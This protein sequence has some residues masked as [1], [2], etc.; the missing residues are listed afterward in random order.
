MH[1]MT[2]IFKA[3]WHGV[4]ALGWLV[5]GLCVTVLI[6]RLFGAP[7]RFY[8]GFVLWL[9]FGWIA[10][11][12][13]LAFSGLHQGPLVSRACAVLALLAFGALA[14]FTLMPPLPKDGH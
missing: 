7:G 1:L 4:T 5:F 3:K 12:L 2:T 8:T 13:L 6:L 11:V 10:P 14:L 9:L